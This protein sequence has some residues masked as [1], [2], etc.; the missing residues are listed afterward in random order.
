[1]S[2]HDPPRVSEGSGAGNSNQVC[3]HDVTN[4]HLCL[5]SKPSLSKCSQSEVL[6]SVSSATA[7]FL[8]ARLALGAIIIRECANAPTR[9]PMDRLR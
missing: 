4:E 7:G 1:M 3:G 9:A 2:V 8:A 6:I 5:L